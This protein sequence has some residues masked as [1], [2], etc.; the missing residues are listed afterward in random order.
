MCVWRNAGGVLWRSIWRFVKIVWGLKLE[1]TTEWGMNDQL[2]E[3]RA[4]MYMDSE[5]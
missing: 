3:Y 5:N 4:F 1:F 2:V